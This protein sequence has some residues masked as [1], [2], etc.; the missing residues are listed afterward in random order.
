MKWEFVSRLGGSSFPC[1]AD[2]VHF[3]L[4]YSGK[5]A[6]G[7]GRGAPSSW[8]NLALSQTRV[9]CR[10]VRLLPAR[11]CVCPLGCGSLS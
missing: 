5:Q 2:N 8:R 11:E 7:L 1:S 9:T 4:P 6:R 10:A 3:L